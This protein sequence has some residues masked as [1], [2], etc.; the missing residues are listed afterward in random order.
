VKRISTVAPD[1]NVN[2]DSS[3]A[4][5]NLIEN[6]RVQ[7]LSREKFVWPDMNEIADEQRRFLSDQKDLI[8][9]EDGLLVDDNNRV[10]IPTQSQALKIRLCIIAHAG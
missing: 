3:T 4:V 9:K 7:P 6:A 5:E 10:V 1:N 8:C 2:Q